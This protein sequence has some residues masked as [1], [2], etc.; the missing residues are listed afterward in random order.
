[1]RSM[2]PELMEALSKLLLKALGEYVVALWDCNKA[3]SLLKGREII[4]FI[5]IIPGMLIVMQE[6]LEMTPQLQKL[7]TALDTWRSITAFMNKTKIVD[8][9]TNELQQ[10]EQ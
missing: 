1:M 9:N 7:C 5:K 8:Q 4:V 10:S 2:T 3:L 6:H